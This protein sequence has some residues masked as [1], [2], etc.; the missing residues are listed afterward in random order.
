MSFISNKHLECVSLSRSCLLDPFSG[1]NS[2][3]TSLLATMHSHRHKV[4][5]YLTG[6]V[7]LVTVNSMLINL[8]AT[9]AM[10]GTSLGKALKEV[11]TYITH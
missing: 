2:P 6:F 5:T 4:Q 11:I 1:A 10:M 8:S 3:P 7:L 9:V